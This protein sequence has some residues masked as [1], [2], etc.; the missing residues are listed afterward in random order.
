MRKPPFQS[1]TTTRRP[2][3]AAGWEDSIDRA[4]A[5]MLTSEDPA[6]RA[7]AARLIVGDMYPSRREGR[8]H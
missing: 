3:T 6:Q 7:I 1:A 4:L 5:R 8:L 2:D